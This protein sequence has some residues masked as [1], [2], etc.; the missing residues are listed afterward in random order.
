MIR[1]LLAV[2]AVAMAFASVQGVASADPAPQKEL[3]KSGGYAGLLNP[4]DLQPFDDQGQ[5]IEFANTGGALVPFVKTP[6]L[7][8]SFDGWPVIPTCSYR[9]TPEGYLL[10]IDIFYGT[11]DTSYYLRA[12]TDGE[13]VFSGP[14]RPTGPA[15]NG[16]DTPGAHDIW[17]VQ[18]GATTIEL[19]DPTGTYVLTSGTINAPCGRFTTHVP[20]PPVYEPPAPSSVTFSEPDRGY[21]LNI[22]VEG[23]NPSEIVQLKYVYANGEVGTIGGFTASAAGAV[24]LLEYSGGLRGQCWMEPIHIAVVRADGTVDS[25]APYFYPDCR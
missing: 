11:G 23:L 18:D 14:M 10:M 1:K 17:G 6:E 12:T 22:L 24:E 19:L 5:C 15:N 9:E 7:W 16:D 8:I 21:G 25:S 20:S 13:Q 2:A 4:A 3:C